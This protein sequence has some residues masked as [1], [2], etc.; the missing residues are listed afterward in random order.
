LVPLEPTEEMVA[1]AAPGREPAEP[2]K[3]SHEYRTWGEAVS[4][5]DTKVKELMGLADSYAFPRTIE[6]NG[7]PPKVTAS[8]M[9]DARVALESALRSALQREPLKHAE[10]LRLRGL[11]VGRIS[12]EL[13]E[14]EFARA[15]ERAHGIDSKDTHG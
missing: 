2:R 11:C 8:D 13:Y 12:G 14:I 3:E 1:A 9:E 7:D 10:L 15:I 6:I 4:T 5:I